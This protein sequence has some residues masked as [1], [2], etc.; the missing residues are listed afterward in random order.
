MNFNNNTALQRDSVSLPYTSL[1]DEKHTRTFVWLFLV[2]LTETWW[3]MNE[4]GVL[5]TDCRPWDRF[6]RCS[7]PLCPVPAS[8]TSEIIVT[9]GLAAAAHSHPV[10]K[11]TRANY[12]ECT[13]SAWSWVL[14][15]HIRVCRNF[16]YCLNL[17]QLIQTNKHWGKSRRFAS[18][19]FQHCCLTSRASVA[20]DPF[21]YSQTTVCHAFHRQ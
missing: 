14:L 16:Y 20:V 21:R 18:L 19:S 12:M 4:V 15:F 3:M 7:W 1:K 13:G 2:N 9:A 8:R 6:R 5:F 11:R 17:W 10:N